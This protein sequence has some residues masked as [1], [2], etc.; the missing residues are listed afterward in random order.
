[1]AKSKDGIL[2]RLGTIRVGVQ[3]RI[4]SKEYFEEA[5]IV[6]M[7]KNF[8]TQFLGLEIKETNK[9]KGEFDIHNLGSQASSALI[10]KLL[11][12]KVELSVS[13]FKQFLASRRETQAWFIF[14]LR[15]L[16]G[17][18]W[19][20]SV[21]RG[22]GPVSRDGWC[23]YANSFDYPHDWVASGQIVSLVSLS[24]RRS[25]LASLELWRSGKV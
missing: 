22:Y 14:F 13:Q 6:F 24:R 2:K 1:M 16:N 9:D 19:A 10:L 8:Q 21:S 23:V 11:G 20:V 12:V 4:T 18:L 15:G 25:G 5:G 7:D 3:P 17:E